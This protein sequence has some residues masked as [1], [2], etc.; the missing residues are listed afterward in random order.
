MLYD[1]MRDVCR[2]HGESI[3]SVLRKTGHSTG[4]TGRWKSGSFPTADVLMDIAE[5]LG[6]SLDE[7]CYGYRSPERLSKAESDLLNVFSLIP[8]E[9]KQ[10]CIDFLKTHMSVPEKSKGKMDA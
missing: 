9:K 7:L 1:I 2:R 4:S 5:C 3:S 6:C 10:I 8:E